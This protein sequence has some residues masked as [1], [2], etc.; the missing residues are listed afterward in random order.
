MACPSRCPQVSQGKVTGSVRPESTRVTLSG[1]GR[2]ALLCQDSAVVLGI[3]EIAKGRGQAHHQVIGPTTHEVMHIVPQ[4][5]YGNPGHLRAVLRFGEQKGREIY[6]GDSEAALGEPD[7]MSPGTTT[8]IQHDATG[9]GNQG[10]ELVDVCFGE[11]ELFL[12]K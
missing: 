2:K 3:V 12:R 9:G 7:S 6:P 5:L 8:E 11:C 10:Q 4:P 1:Q